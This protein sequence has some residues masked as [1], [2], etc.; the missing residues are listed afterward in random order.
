[1]F[2]CILTGL[3]TFLLWGKVWLGVIGFLA[4]VLV[5]RLYRSRAA[6]FINK[7][8]GVEKAR[9]L[10]EVSYSEDGRYPK[11]ED[12]E[13]TLLVNFRNGERL[14][15]IVHGDGAIYRELKSYIAN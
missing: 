5:T 4:G 9:V 15:Y 2:Y 8:G 1:M 12:K 7:R 3:L 11:A 10:K 14:R 13:Y 6:Y